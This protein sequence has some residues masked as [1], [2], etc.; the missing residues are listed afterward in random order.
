MFP[1]ED[2][3]AV[4]R[5]YFRAVLTHDRALFARSVLTDRDL[6][7]LLPPRSPRCALARLIAEVERAVVSADAQ[8][9]PRTL[10]R[11]RLAGTTH[12]MMVQRTAAGPRIDL[13]EGLDAAAARTLAVAAAC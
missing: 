7:G 1:A 6:D 12:L 5:A 4:V 9:L 8:H 2:L 11:V 10:V 13:R 3:T